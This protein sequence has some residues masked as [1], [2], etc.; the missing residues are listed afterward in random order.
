YSNTKLDE[1]FAPESNFNPTAE[2]NAG[3]NYREWIAHLS[4][5]YILP[6]DISVGLNFSHQ[7]GNPQ[8]RTLVVRAPQCGNVTL[9]VVP[10]GILRLPNV[11]QVTF[12]ASKSFRLWRQNRVS[13]RLNVYN[14]TNA[15]TVT[16]RTVQSGTSYLVPTSQL[17]PRILEFGATY[18]F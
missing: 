18:S 14:L 1:P 2:I 8:A 3:S 16:G 17:P 12:S 6:R 7:S 9:R 4:G 10:L 5:N 13:A 15:N 11:N